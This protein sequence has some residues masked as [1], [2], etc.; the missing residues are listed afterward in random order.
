MRRLP[1]DIRVGD[2]LLE[3]P[4]GRV[5]GMRSSDNATHRVLHF[6]KHTPVIVRDAQTTFRPVGRR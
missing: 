2:V 3:C 6:N 1:T 4:Y 5:Q